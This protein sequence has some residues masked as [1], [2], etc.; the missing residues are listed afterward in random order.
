MAA[1]HCDGGVARAAYVKRREALIGALLRKQRLPQRRYPQSAVSTHN[2]TLRYPLLCH[3]PPEPVSAPA[4]IST[5]LR[6]QHARS[7]K[8]VREAIEGSLS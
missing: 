6:L 4:A 8:S 1:G 3:T 2:H 7:S 5:S